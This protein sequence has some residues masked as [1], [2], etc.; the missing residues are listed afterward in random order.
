MPRWSRRLPARSRCRSI[1][2]PGLNGLRRRVPDPAR[3]VPLD[4]AGWRRSRRIGVILSAVYMLWMFQRVFF[5][6]PSDWMRRCWPALTR[7]DAASGSRSRRSSCWSW[8]WACSRT[9]SS[10]PPRR[11]CSASSRPSGPPAG[12]RSCHGEL[13]DERHR[14]PQRPVPALPGA[15]PA[16]RRCSSCSPPTSSCHPL[17]VAASRRSRSSGSARR[18]RA[19]SIVWGRHATVFD[20][21]YR[22]DDLSVF[23]KA[24]DRRH[25]HPVGALR[26]SYLEQRAPAARRVQRDPPVRLLGMCVLA[27]SDDLIT[28]FIG[29]ELMIDAVYVLTGLPQD[30]SATATRAASSTS[31]S[32]AFSS[33]FL[34]FG[35]AWTFGLTGSTQLAASRGAGRR[36]R[37]APARRW[38]R[39]PAHGRRRVQGRGRPVPL[40]DAGRLPGRADAGHRLPVG[41]R[42]RLGAFALA[43]PRLR[44]GARPRSRS[45][46]S[47]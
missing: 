9:A 3:R 20:G 43:R 39:S 42:R 40:L 21:F 37:S 17:E 22:V 30:R 31:C 28:L 13:T 16:P 15:D 12:S 41:R 34:L 35:I 27:S 10:T 47:S 1:G 29:L 36:S 7:H 4:P 44:R 6:V 8:P 24:A 2:L 38:S 19:A 46:G 45:T 23:F 14:L 26:A 25:R 18:H 11:R 32:A 33:A 5:T